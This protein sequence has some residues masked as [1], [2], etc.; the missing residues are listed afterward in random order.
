MD[1]DDE[2]EGEGLRVDAEEDEEHGASAS[3]VTNTNEDGDGTPQP[4]EKTK[5]IKAPL[6]QVDFAGLDMDAA[7]AQFDND[8]HESSKRARALSLDAVSFI[9][10]IHEAIEMIT[11]LLGSTHK[12]EVLESMDFFRTAHEFDISAAKVGVSSLLRRSLTDSPFT[13]RSVS[14]G[15]FISSGRR[16]TAQPPRTG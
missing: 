7:F 5:K 11:R 1:V 16:T 13:N 10:S 4:P 8:K 3:V 6:P 12:A 2:Q 9:E 14:E 15:C